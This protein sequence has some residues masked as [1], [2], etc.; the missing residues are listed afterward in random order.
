[1]N[2]SFSDIWNCPEAFEFI[3]TKKWDGLNPTDVTNVRHCDVCSENVYF[4][5][6]P[7]EFVN[8]SKLGR[9]VAL[10][11]RAKPPIDGNSGFAGRVSPEFVVNL[12]SHQK[13]YKVWWNMVLN[14]EPYFILSLI[15]KEYPDVVAFLIG[16]GS[17]VFTEDFDLLG[18]A[19]YLLSNSEERDKFALHLIEIGQVDEAVKIAKTLKDKPDSLM[20]MILKLV[21]VDKF[22]TALEIILTLADHKAQLS[23]LRVVIGKLQSLGQIETAIE[24]CKGYLIK[25]KN[26][27]VP[28]KASVLTLLSHLRSQIPQSIGLA[29]AIATEFIHAP[30]EV[31]PDRKAM[32][33]CILDIVVLNGIPYALFG[34][35]T[36]TNPYH[37]DTD[38]N[39]VLPLL[40]FKN[41][42]LSQPTGLPN[43]NTTNGGALRGS[44]SGGKVL[45]V[46]DVC[47]KTLTSQSVADE[48]CRR[49]GLQ[50]LGED[51][52]RM[53]EFHDGDRNAGWA[54]WDFWADA[55]A[56]PSL[57]ISNV[58]Y[59]VSINDQPANPWS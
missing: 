40:C 20:L 31:Q 51:G 58:R 39:A 49:Q 48:Y 9:C 47:G 23:G 17:N 18:Q 57:R 13:R 34:T 19:Y 41:L 30:S 35:D 4:S 28:T 14:Y 6:T 33:W 50:V 1:M 15:K 36:L 46:P 52:F 16:L 54:G 32:T 37:G 56:M 8:N 44:W 3:C 45:I 27:P 53:A 24:F 2:K 55:S 43:S 7:E 22:E 5:S 10:P 26:L 59:W 25:A 11:E 42:G 21:E 38:T 12:V 29:E